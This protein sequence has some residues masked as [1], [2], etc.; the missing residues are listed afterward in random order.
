MV[1]DTQYQNLLARLTAL[2]QNQNDMM[3]AMGRFITLTQVNQIN[4]ILQTDIQ[5]LESSVDAL[6]ARVQ[7][8]ESEPLA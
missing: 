8:L 5:T 7:E 3:T 1:T 4:T 2:E 6:E